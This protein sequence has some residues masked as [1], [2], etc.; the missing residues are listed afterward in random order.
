VR[1]DE[2]TSVQRVGFPPRK[3]QP[4]IGNR[5][6]REVTNTTKRRQSDRQ[7]AT[8]VKRWSLVTTED[9]E[10]DRVLDREGNSRRGLLA[11]APETLPGS[12][13][14]AC[15]ERGWVEELGKPLEVSRSE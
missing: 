10:A 3:A 2:A 6:L 1:R 14:V 9:A 4:A 8:Q 15:L 11:T 12:E 5:V 13:S 7:A